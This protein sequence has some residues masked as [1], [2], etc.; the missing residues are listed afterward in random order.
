MGNETEN[1]WV[2]KQLLLWNEWLEEDVREIP[3]IYRLVTGPFLLEPDHE[4]NIG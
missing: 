3:T 1:T 4:S 2:I